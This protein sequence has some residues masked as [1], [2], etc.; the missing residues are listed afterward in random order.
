M[1]CHKQGEVSVRTGTEDRLFGTG[2]KFSVNDFSSPKGQDIKVIGAMQGIDKRSSNY[3][4][5]IKET[6]RAAI[7]FDSGSLA[8]KLA[9]E[10]STT[11]SDFIFKRVILSE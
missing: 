7:L 9:A 1:L 4:N 8:R 10:L 5:Q 3:S 2:G 11:V 6:I